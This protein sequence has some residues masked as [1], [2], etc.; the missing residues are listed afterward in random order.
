MWEVQ[1]LE[2]WIQH[3]RQCEVLHLGDVHILHAT[4]LNIL[5]ESKAPC[6]DG[7][8][9]AHHTVVVVEHVLARR[10]DLVQAGDGRKH[11][12]SGD[13]VAALKYDGGLVERL[14]Q[15]GDLGD[16]HPLLVRKL[17]LVVGM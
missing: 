10:C 7:G 9:H 6:D 13:V 4:S 12:G 8:V 1:P 16:D 14:E 11:E 15:K 17:V 5:V 3:G 2:T